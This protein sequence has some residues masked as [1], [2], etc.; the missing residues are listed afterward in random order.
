MPMQPARRRKLFFVPRLELIE[1]RTLPSL[2]AWINPLGGDWDN[3]LNWLGAQVPGPA[4][5]ALISLPGI[6][7]THA[8]AIADSVQSLSSTAGIDISA[9]SLS[10]AAASTATSLNLTG[11]TLT[12]AG[13][14]T[15]A[16]LFNWNA[17]TLSG[18]GQLNATGGTYITGPCSKTLDGRPLNLTGTI[19]WTG[20]DINV[21]NGAVITNLTGSVFT[22]QV[23][24]AFVASSTTALPTF[25][26]YGTFLK[27]GGTG[28]TAIGMAFNNKGTVL[29][30]Q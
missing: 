5:T 21:A 19:T 17:G 6:T 12:G 4:D 14:L 29:V 30:H 18:S 9:G 7:V 16:G 2:V 1:E 25:N 10:L 13:N 27:S 23:D 26:N 28:T 24:A 20:A 15:V 3:P 8:S 22:D 11:G